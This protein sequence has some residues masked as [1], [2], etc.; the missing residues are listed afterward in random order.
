MRPARR[1][2]TT[3][4]GV[5][6]DLLDQ[7]QAALTASD[8]EGRITHWNRQAEVLFGWPAEEALG[9]NFR[10]L[11]IGSENAAAADLIRE[12]VLSGQAWEGEF[13]IPR[14]DGR[15]LLSY[16]TLSPIRDEAGAVSGIVSVSIDITDRVHQERLLAAR[17]TVTHTL[18]EATDLAEATPRIMAAVC[19]NLG[20][21]VGVLWRMDDVAG[22]ARCVHVWHQPERG[23]ASFEEATRQRVFSPGIGLPGRVWESGRPAWIPDVDK[24]SNFPRAPAAAVEGLHGAFGFPILLG[25]TVLGV[26]EFFSREIR[27][28]DDLLLQTM[29]VIGSQIGQ[30]MQRLAAQE[31][32]RES[33]ER[34][35][36]ALEAGRL[37]TWRWDIATRTVVWDQT[38]ES[39]YGLPPGGFKGTYEEY[40]SLLHPEDRDW[41][42]DTVRKSVETGSGHQFEHRVVWP[43]GSLHWIEGRGH[44]VRDERGTVLGMVGVS[45]DITR[46]KLEE[47]AQ[48]FL[49]EAGALL[50]SSLDYEETLKRVAQLAVSSVGGIP[51]A[52]WCAV[53]IRAEDGE[54]R[55]LAVEHIDPAKVQLAAEV[56]RRYPQDPHAPTGVPE[57]IRSGRSEIYP[58]VPDELLVQAARDEKHLATLR[59]LGMRSVLIVPMPV[60][61]RTLG[62]ITFVSA[63]SGRR[64]AQEDLAFVEDLARR[65][66]LAVENSRLY[67][68]KKEVAQKLQ[69]GLLPPEL[70]EIPN[71][72]LAGRYRWGGQGSEIGGDFYDAF[73]TGDGSWGLVIGDVCGKGPEAAVVTGLA[74]Y[75]IRAVA[76]RETK[77]SRVLAAL[78]E[79]VRQQRSDSTF[80]TVIYVRMRPSDQ[81]AR[82]TICC[83]GH[84][85]PL[86]LRSDGSIEQAGT[87]GTLLGIF[88]DPDLSDRVVD[89]RRGDA[90]VLFTDGVE[91][92][93]PGAMFGMDRLTSVVRSAQGSNANGI[94]EAIEHAVLAFRPEALRDDVAVLV[95]RVAP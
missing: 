19:E 64:Y 3:G 62:A 68:A 65:A 89:L 25:G 69:E 83:A 72:E 77:P 86:V 49:A 81:G 47:E 40:V 70:P 29:G 9:R 13:P 44:V 85:L 7:V 5:A 91:E 15:P 74:R 6:G 4:N 48:R 76:L 75:T 84:P 42:T 32:L 60:A 52:D 92:R 58:D 22:V 79:A 59:S 37:G 94:A 14:K 11:L 41:V 95:M 56:Q 90:I 46:R 88:A 28:P 45:T 27:E 87:P 82:L 80:C 35:R 54:V 24:D 50:A 18:A 23:A 16:T 66:A 34:L 93:A 63:E 26:M 8:L 55:A 2:P 73:P 10:D 71:I 20:W 43:D 38:L 53:H 33:S 12:R 51:L 21:E 31:S 30:F 78:N 17:T 57:V 39:I 1:A 61:G 67:Q 36:L